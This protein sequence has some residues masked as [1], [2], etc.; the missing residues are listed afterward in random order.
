MRHPEPLTT[1]STTHRV[2][3]E[4]ET[5]YAVISGTSGTEYSVLVL[6]DGT[7]S[8]TCDWAHYRPRK[9]N[10][11]CACS[12]VLAVMAERASDDH[13]KM[14]AWANQASAK[15]Q[16]RKTTDLVDGIYLTL[17]KA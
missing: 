17:R 9:N 16:H 13:R 7:A 10:G 8:C 4:T 3:R 1:K 6:A 12:H 5:S 14:K 2:I 11:A 15:R